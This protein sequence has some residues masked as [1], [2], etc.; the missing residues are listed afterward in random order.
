MSTK[1]VV[2]KKV[3]EK[4]PT[5]RQKKEVRTPST[6]V[7]EKRTTTASKR[8][9]V[10][11]VSAK[12]TSCVCRVACKPEEA[13]WIHHGPVVASVAEL[14]EA[15]GEMTDE[16]YSY[17]TRRN[18]N[19]FA[20]WLRDCFGKDALASRVEGATSRAKAVQALRSPCCK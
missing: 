9:A 11:K 7:K 20:V 19:D 16:Q 4:M 17:H 12:D 5:A 8:V 15:L 13:F 1:T 18:G 2:Q 10:K 3:E 14:M 6:V